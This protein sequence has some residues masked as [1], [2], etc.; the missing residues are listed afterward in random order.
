MIK[1]YRE[2][3]EGELAKICEDILDASS[4]F[5]TGTL[6]LRGIRG[7]QSLLPQDVGPSYFCPHLESH[8]FQDT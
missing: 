5:L 7:I 2:K 4:T 6:P 1:G 8:V 3:I